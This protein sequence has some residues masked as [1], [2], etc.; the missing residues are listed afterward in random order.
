MFDRILIGLD[1]SARALNAIR[2]AHR[3]GLL[4]ASSKVR[5]LCALQLSSWFGQSKPDEAEAAARKSVLAPGRA[6]LEELGVSD[7]T[8]EVTR[9]GPT[10][11]ILELAESGEVDLIVLGRRGLGAIKSLLLGSVSRKVLEHSGV[12]SLIVPERVIT[13]APKT[14]LVPTDFSPGA[15]HALLVASVLARQSDLDLVLLNGRSLNDFLRNQTVEGPTIH[16]L[17]L[18]EMFE[19]HEREIHERLEAAVARLK[20]EKLKASSERFGGDAGEGIA[21]AAE[22]RPGSLIVMASHGRSGLRKLWL[23]SVA[24]RVVRRSPTPALIVPVPEGAG[25]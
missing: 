9:G 2:Q 16:A 17:K 19:K 7:I 3:V 25:L 20:K 11:A 4:T 8:E 15:D 22:A 5:L 18:A 24:A 13:E 12:P 10:E 21:K 14:I 6:I 1:G 23:G